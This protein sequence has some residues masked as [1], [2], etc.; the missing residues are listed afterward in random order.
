MQY[1]P[2]IELMRT[3]DMV[4]LSFAE[5][6]MKSAGIFYLLTDQN[7]SIAEGSLGAIQCRL[8]VEKKRSK[9]AK[10]ILIE[11]G[12]ADELYHE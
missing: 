9:E 5:S 4:L 12:L 7:T 2:M 3:N 11:A 8:I 6:L 10:Q 1:S